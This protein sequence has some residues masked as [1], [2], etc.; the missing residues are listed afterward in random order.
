M[1]FTKHLA[2]ESKVF[3]ISKDG[4]FLVI[5]KK[6]WK[7]IK[8]VRLALVLVQQLAKSLEDFLKT[9]DFYTTMR[10]G[11]RIFIAQRLSNIRGYLAVVAYGNC[12]RHNFIILPK[13]KEGQGWRR[14]AEVMQEVSSEGSGSRDD[15]RAPLKSMVVVAQSTEMHLQEGAGEQTSVRGA[16]GWR[17]CFGNSLV[18]AR[19]RLEWVHGQTIAVPEW[20]MVLVL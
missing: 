19:L 4:S 11:N 15:V 12:S 9:K 18:W 8:M 3:T 10:K 13:V 17:K 1:G 16:W 6:S 14:M 7:A 20:A 2:L 5:T